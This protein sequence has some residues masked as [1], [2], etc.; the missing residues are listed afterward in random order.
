MYDKL[1]GRLIKVC[2]GSLQQAHREMK[3]MM[4]SLAQRRKGDP[5]TRGP[6]KVGRP[7]LSP[8]EWKRLEQNV[9]DREER[10]KPL[11]YVLGTQPFCGLDILLRSPVLIPR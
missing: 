10:S 4:D 6:S 2:D 7:I 3:W 8:S 1:V 11:Q 9:R 5:S